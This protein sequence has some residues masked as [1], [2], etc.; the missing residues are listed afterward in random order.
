VIA[1]EEELLLRN[2]NGWSTR[3]IVA[4]LLGW[5]LYIIEGSNQIM[6]GDLPFYDIDPGED[7]SK[8]NAVLVR[9]YSSKN[10]HEL[11]D[12]LRASAQELIQFLRSLG[13]SEWEQDYGVRHKE[14]IITIK[15][16]MD[17][18]IE[19]YDIHRE[20]IANWAAS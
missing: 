15:N 4:H 9:E 17:E 5:N 11:L 3:D 1:L 20:R 19:D 10:K 7:Y 6:R 13:S 14:Q 16:T 12:E 18:L 2:I 8:V